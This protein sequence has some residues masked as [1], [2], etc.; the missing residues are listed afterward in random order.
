MLIKIKK[1]ASK[2]MKSTLRSLMVLFLFIPMLAISQ[3]IDTVSVT[4][5][6]YGQTENEAVTD[7]IVNAISQ[8]NGES[9]ASSIRVSKKV[10]SSTG[11]ATKAERT[12]DND[13]SRKTQGIVKSWKKVSQATQGEGSISVSVAVS[14]FVLQKS[15]QL[16]RMK[17]AVVPKSSNMDELSDE[18]IANMTS[19]LVS[20]RKFAVMDRRQGE[21]ISNQLDRIRHSGGARQ[22]GVRLNAE[23]APDYIAVVSAE[24][25]RS[26]G[27]KKSLRASIEFIDY[28]T[29]QIKFSSTKSIPVKEVDKASIAKR[30]SVVAKALSRSVLDTVYPPIVV[31]FESGFVTVAQGS[32]FFNVGDKCELNEIKEAIQ[33]PYTKE[34]L[35]NDQATIGQV[36]IVYVDKRI[37][38]A[39]LLTNVE[40]TTNKI[41]NKK[42]TVHRTGKSSIDLFGEATSDPSKLESTSAQSPDF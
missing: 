22:D 7:A 23:L 42:Y 5:I 37:S 6:G 30:L 32:D 33:D 35:G 12:V 1:S 11:T 8:V 31:G 41:V 26:T 29:R 4:V 39:K 15:E 20:S 27:D 21:A 2:N 36:E 16:N 13:I 40:L 9:I 3:K 28:A 25:M 38:K 17:I 24:L 34:F 19:N 14:V 10:A 18:L